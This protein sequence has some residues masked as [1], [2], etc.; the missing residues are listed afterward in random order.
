MKGQDWEHWL[1]STNPKTKPVSIVLCVGTKTAI[2][3]SISFLVKC[4]TYQSPKISLHTLLSSTAHLPFQVTGSLPSHL[5]LHRPS[6]LYPFI[7]K[8]WYLLYLSCIGSLT[9]CLHIEKLADQ[10]LSQYIY[11]HA[12]PTSMALLPQDQPRQELELL[13]Y[14]ALLLCAKQSDRHFKY[15]CPNLSIYAGE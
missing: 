6:V 1:K 15:T 13:T 9:V 4:F 8:V 12:P 2:R 10:I 5:L 7:Q 14:I 3:D 11:T